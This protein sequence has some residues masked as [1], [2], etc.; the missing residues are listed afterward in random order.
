LYV[1]AGDRYLG[2]DGD[3]QSAVRC[4]GQALN[5]D[6]PAVLAIDPK[7]NWLLMAIKDARKKEKRHESNEK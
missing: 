5:L 4:Y 1:Q 6:D 3:V 2:E 7:D